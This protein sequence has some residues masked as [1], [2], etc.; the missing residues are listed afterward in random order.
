M[1]QRVFNPWHIN[2]RVQ[3]ATLHPKLL[4]VTLAIVKGIR[5]IGK[6]V[7]DIIRIQL[8]SEKWLTRYMLNQRSSF[9]L[10]I[11]HV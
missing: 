11:G 7:E 5:N 2:K 10:S 3:R 4:I 8:S 9:Y 1:M 6:V